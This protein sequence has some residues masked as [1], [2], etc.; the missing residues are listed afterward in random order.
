M[1]EQQGN[2]FDVTV[3]NVPRVFDQLKIDEIKMK[4]LNAANR[5]YRK[6]VTSNCPPPIDTKTQRRLLMIRRKKYIKFT[7]PRLQDQ[8]LSKVWKKV[9]RSHRIKNLEKDLRELRIRIVVAESKVH[10]TE[11]ER[12]FKIIIGTIK[13]IESMDTEINQANLEINHIK[14]QIERVNQKKVELGRETESEGEINL[15]FFLFNL[16]VVQ[17]SRL[18]CS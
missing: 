18:N 15:H 1:E 6:C 3:H 8:K 12:N 7:T 2:Q 11:Q 4:D 16:K 10:V 17:A 14:S 13:E 5:T 9:G